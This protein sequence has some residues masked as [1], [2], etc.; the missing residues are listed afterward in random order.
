M[1]MLFQFD[2]DVSIDVIQNLSACLN[3]TVNAVINN[4]KL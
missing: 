3:F 4:Y 1:A 2:Q